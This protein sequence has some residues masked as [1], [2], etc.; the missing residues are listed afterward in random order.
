MPLRMLRNRDFSGP[1]RPRKAE[2]MICCLWAAALRD[3]RDHRLS[4][5][6]PVSNCLGLA[7]IRL[8]AGRLTIPSTQRATRPWWSE[9]QF[10]RRG[11]LNTWNQSRAPAVAGAERVD[12]TEFRAADAQSCLV[13][14]LV[15]RD[16]QGW[17]FPGR[18]ERDG[19]RR[20]EWRLG[21]RLGS[22]A[23]VAWTHRIYNLDALRPGIRK[24]GF[25]E[26]M[27]VIRCRHL[28]GLLPSVA[29]DAQLGFS[30]RAYQ[31]AELLSDR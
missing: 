16:Y 12:S 15:R 10:S 20:H 28:A 2:G 30:A 27:E 3:Y 14:P 31:P 22:N 29:I 24:T 4:R 6:C 26:V 25:R 7:G 18:K 23:S 19:H 11:I 17:G 5:P 8:E 9:N 1:R 13:C 21:V